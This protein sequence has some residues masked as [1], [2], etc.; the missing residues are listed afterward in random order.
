MMTGQ[1]YIESLKQLK[2]PVYYRGRIIE[3][4]VEHP[5]FRPHIN[6]AAVT[7]DLAHDPEQGS[8]ATTTSHLT[9]QPI[10]RFTHIHHSAQDLVTK[11]KLMRT[12]GRQTGTCFQRCVGFDGLNAVYGV[13]FEMDQKEGTNYHQRFLEYL[14][15]IQAHDLMVD[16][17]MTDPKGDRSRS[18]GQQADPDFYLHVVERRADGIVVQGAKAQQ[19]G[20]INSHEVLVM[21]TAAMD[22]ADADYAVSFAVP[23]NTP[24]LTFIFGRQANDTRREEGEIDQGNA[25]FGIMGGEALIVFDNVFVP[26]ERVFM[27]GE[28]GYTGLLVERFASYHRQNYGGCKT[29]V[30]DVLVGAAYTAAQYQGTERAAHIRDKLTEMVHLAETLYACSIACSAEGRPTPSGQ[31]FVD[32]L[33][34]NTAKLN[35]T[36]F[37]YE[38]ARL[39]HDIAGG[40][41]ATLPSEQDLR[42]P[43]IGPYVAKYFQGVAEVPMEHRFRICRLIENMTANTALVESMHG[44]GSPQAQRIMILR[45]ANLEEK[46]ALATRLAGIPNTQEKP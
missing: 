28:Y 19:T 9:G 37:I 35:T 4:V 8:L 41:I 40:L 36:R 33:L 20:A 3:D 5:A 42:H 44:A 34:A 25:Q 26:W 21:P 45:Q 23:A 11:V 30:A 22:P 16:G 15:Y 31:Y 43:E 27:C 46:K 2:R 38:I 14:K 24:G 18:P 13:T 17:A 32:P 12:L 39:V 29:G 6:A 1:E 7:Y 10:S